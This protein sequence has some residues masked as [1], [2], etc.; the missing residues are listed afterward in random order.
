MVF[1][2]LFNVSL[3]QVWRFSPSESRHSQAFAVLLYNLSGTQAAPS[4]W[5]P[6][7]ATKAH[8]PDWGQR[9]ILPF[10]Q[11]HVSS[12]QCTVDAQQ[13]PTSASDVLVSGMGTAKVMLTLLEMGASVP[14]RSPQLGSYYAFTQ[15]PS[16]GRGQKMSLSRRAE[17]KARGVGPLEELWRQLWAG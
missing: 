15:D 12:S 3:T 9:I 14:P 6:P 5:D 10:L 17:K 8:G 16:R 7:P 1:Y 4:Y 13:I 11:A 2:L